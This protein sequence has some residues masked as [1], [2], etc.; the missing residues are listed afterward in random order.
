MLLLDKRQPA[1]RSPAT[2]PCGFRPLQSPA[3]SMDPASASS[4]SPG[5]RKRKVI[6][7]DCGEKRARTYSELEY[8]E[9]LAEAALLREELELLV[10][11]ALDLCEDLGLD[12]GRA[13]GFSAALQQ[14]DELL[15]AREDVTL[16]QIRATCQ[17]MLAMTQYLCRYHFDHFALLDM[18]DPL[19]ACRDRFMRFVLRHAAMLGL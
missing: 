10:A 4:A 3:A 11:V 8:E 12:A 2:S 1:I 14:V 5:S 17:R 9:M 13:R 7:D 15:A 16:R 19:V 6:V 18:Q